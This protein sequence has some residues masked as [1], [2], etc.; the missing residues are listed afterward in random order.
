ME[1]IAMA[2]TRVTVDEWVEMFRAIGLKESDMHKW[3]AEFERRHPEAHESFLEWLSLPEAR[4]TEIRRKSA[5]D[6]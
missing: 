4:I 1:E 2:E 3:H 5:K 6:W